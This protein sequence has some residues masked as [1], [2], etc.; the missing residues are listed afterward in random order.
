M[1]IISKRKIDITKPSLAKKE[2]SLVLKHRKELKKIIKSEDD[3]FIIVVGPCSAWP[4][5]AVFEYAKQLKRISDLV[6]DKLKIVLRVY[7][8]KPRTKVGWAG[9]LV[10]PDPF[11]KPD[12]KKGIEY[13]SDLDKKL[14]ELDL[15]LC[16]EFLFTHKSKWVLDFL[17]MAVLGA[18]SAEDQEHRAFASMLDL[19][20][21]IK[22]PTSGLIEIGIN[23]VV[24]A[25]NEHS[26]YFDGYQIDTSGNEFAFLILRGG[27]LGSNYKEKDIK[28]AIKTMKS[29]GVKN[30]SIFVDLSHD[31]SIFKGKKDFKRQEHVANYLI[32]VLKKDKELKKF[33][34]GVFIES[35]LYEGN[36]KPKSKDDVKFG[37]SITDACIDIKTTEKIIMNIYSSI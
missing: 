14:I 33:L 31:N 36:Q 21:G 3:R 30:P 8:Q 22:N 29:E 24:S 1:G 12:I 26:F 4:K 15:P 34:K 27:Y 6:S 32:R 16:D 37:V 20:C 19:L 23:G 10:Q 2:K 13:I 28:K 7:T 18:R 35:F 25:Q 9:V 5:E 17:S 11:K